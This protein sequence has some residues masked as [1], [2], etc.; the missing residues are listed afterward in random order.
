[1]MLNPSQTDLLG[2]WQRLA[3]YTVVGFL[4][5]MSLSAKGLSK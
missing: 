5:F 4:I 1:M 3:D 2:L